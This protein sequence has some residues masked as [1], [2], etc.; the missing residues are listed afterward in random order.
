MQPKATEVLGLGSEAKH[1][2]EALTHPS[3]ANER[4]GTRDNQRLE[5]LGDAVLGF[6]TTEILFLRYPEAAE[7]ELT[8]MRSSLVNAE[9]LAAWGRRHEVA[10]MIRLGK[11]AEGSKLRD[12]TNV[13]ADTVEA[14]VAAVYL[15][16]GLDAARA[17]CKRIVEDEL[18]SLD[19]GA[20]RDP[21]SELQERVQSQGL[22]APTYEVLESGGP[23]HDRWFE[24]GVR[25]DGRVVGRGAG[26]SKR[27]AEQAAAFAALRAEYAESPDTSAAAASEAPAVPGSDQ[28]S[29]GG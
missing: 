5:L 19:A 29:L 25:I 7:G 15:D 28:G 21:K 24:V 27:Q 12:S 2:D 9:A 14:L 11:G 8:R 20:S 3:Y 23:A 18:T 22:A 13:L 17:A 26:R 6:C 16:Y 10:G 4:P 1:L